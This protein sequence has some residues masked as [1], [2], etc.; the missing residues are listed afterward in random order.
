MKIQIPE[1]ANEIITTLTAAGYEAYVVGGCVRDAIPG[2][3]S[4]R[5]GY[6]HQRQAG[7]GQ[8]LI[9][10]DGGH[11]SPARHRNGCLNGKEGFEVTTYRIDGEYLDGR[12]RSRYF[13]RRIFWKI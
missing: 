10:P 11:R 2:T 1:K 4:G 12:H 13:L 7:A 9:S 6:H 8:S 3:G 5:L